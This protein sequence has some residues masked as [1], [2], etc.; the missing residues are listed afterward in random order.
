M[1]KERKS[2]G[3]AAVLSFFVPG[4]G[5]IYNGQIGRGILF[6]FIYFILILLSFVLIGIPFLLFFWMYGMYDA[7]RT[8][9]ATWK[10]G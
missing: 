5:Q 10:K 8:A 1:A 4:L 3:I 6:I 2:S 9:E 7:Y